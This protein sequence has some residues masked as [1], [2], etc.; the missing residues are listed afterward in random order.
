M[1]DVEGK[2]GPELAQHLGTELSPFQANLSG[3][4]L[5]TP[6]LAKSDRYLASLCHLFPASGD[7]SGNAP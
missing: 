4:A 5:E 1:K 3:L 7:L 6:K 2:D